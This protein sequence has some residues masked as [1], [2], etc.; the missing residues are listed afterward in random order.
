MIPPDH[1]MHRMSGPPERAKGYLSIGPVLSIAVLLPA[2]VGDLGRHAVSPNP[3]MKG[4][5]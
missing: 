1:P 5:T 4:Q 3:P 2:L